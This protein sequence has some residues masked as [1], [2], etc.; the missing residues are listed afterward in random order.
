MVRLPADG[1]ARGVSAVLMVPTAPPIFDPSDQRRC[2]RR[3]GGFTM[4]EM[5]VTISIILLLIGVSVVGLSQI[6]KH[7]KAQHTKAVLG[8]AQSMLAEFEASAG[9]QSKADFKRFSE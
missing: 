1:P 6:A 9:T 7:S 5:L 4:I 3:R 2:R 8:A